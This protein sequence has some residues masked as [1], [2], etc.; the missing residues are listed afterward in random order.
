MKKSENKK[1]V[2]NVVMLYIFTFAK[3]IFPL[4]TLPYLT[5]VLSEDSYGVVSYVKSFM[6]YM[7]LII[8]FGFILSAVKDIVKVQ[9]NREEVGYIAGHTFLAKCLLII[10]T[11]ILL[12]IFCVT[13]PILRTNLFYTMLSFAAVALTAFLPDFL[14]RGLEKMGF[15][16]LTFVV[17]KGI[18][19]AMTFV[20][21]TND[22]TIM[23]IPLFE[24]IGTLLAVII[25]WV[26]IFLSKIRVRIKSFKTTLR[27]LKESSTYFFSNFA[28]TALGALNTIVIGIVLIDN[29]QIAFWSVCMQIITAVQNLY[30]PIQNGIYPRMVR[31]KDLNFMHKIMLVF[32]PIVLAGSL[33]CFF[34][35]EKIIVI[36]A[37]A[38]YID[39]HILFR[40]LIPILIFSFPSI[41]YGWTTLGVINKEKLT[42]LTTIITA[43][44]QILGLA[45]LIVFDQFTLIN[46]AILR[47]FSEFVFMAIRMIFTYKYRKL[48]NKKS[49]AN[50]KECEVLS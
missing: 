12:C 43:V 16:T 4:L 18:S 14:F 2:E 42:T 5:R 3:L 45:L 20:F 1:T 33:F 22:N 36:I 30:M 26:L 13:I 50:L 27:M 44:T 41:M 34:F 21:V 19:T 49:S 37:G 46:V 28:T 7:Q 17:M 47:C 15:I 10:I 48:F 35:S 40:Y 23:Y 24:L 9:N 25:G 8:D 38:K 6:I 29:A 39:A 11:F 32:M 31:Y